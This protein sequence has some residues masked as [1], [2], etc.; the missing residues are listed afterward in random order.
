MSKIS[1]LW[2][3]KS[4]ED[5]KNALEKYWNYVKPENSELEK[6]LNE[7]KFEQ[8]FELDQLGWYNFLRDKYFRWK[9]T[10]PNRY[11]TTTKCLKRYL[12]SEQLNILFDIKERLLTLDLSDIK[13]GLLA[14]KEIKGLGVAGASGLLSLMYPHTF[15]TV[16]Q[17][18]VKALRLIYDLP[19]K[20]LLE[21]M[22][23][24]SLTLNN[25]VIL[26]NIMCRKAEENN[27]IFHTDYWT[28]R[29]IDMVLWG[30]R[31]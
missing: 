8:I 16:D 19:E 17:F 10:S 26:I 5:W 30:S 9:Y 11:A 1:D 4:E 13:T 18:A 6:S 28:P 29:K 20:T 22:K 3:S 14:A 12:D 23:P 27:D 2:Y 21:R 7:L 31:E 24:D 15:A 25:G